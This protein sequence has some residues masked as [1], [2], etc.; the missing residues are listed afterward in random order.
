M[1]KKIKDRFINFI[2][3]RIS[4]LEINIKEESQ[5]IEIKLLEAQKANL[6]T[7]QDRIDSATKQ[8][9]ER[10][11]V[12][13]LEGSKCTSKDAKRDLLIV[14]NRL[15]NQLQSLSWLQHRMQITGNLPPL[16][17][18]AASP[19]VLLMLHAHIRD[20]R[21]QVIVEF[22]SGASTLVIADA[23]KQ[24]KSG[25]LY[26]IEHIQK[27][28]DETLT[29]LKA[30]NLQDRVDL[31]CAELEQWEGPHLNDDN[32]KSSLWY[33]QSLLEGISKVDLAWID[34]PPASVSN[35]SRFPAVPALVDH[36]TSN[37]QVWLDDTTR[38]EE[39]EICEY[40][41]KE[42]NLRV[43][44]YTLEKGLGILTRVK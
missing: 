29:N 31:R 21:P 8:E 2:D 30:E 41:S 14:Q 6:D 38:R 20:T 19:D 34:G 11:E 39:K 12:K 42:H 15:Y 1:I 23:L 10:L 28:A 27:Y 25:R 5:R 13:L 32:D 18:W 17:G 16:R 4:A 9:S 44:Y 43:E 36:F 40:W 7:L 33:A 37:T 3:S 35:F 26:S 22:G 24:N